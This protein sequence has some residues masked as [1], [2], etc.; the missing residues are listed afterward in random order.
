[1]LQPFISLKALISSV[2]TFMLLGSFGDAT[3]I[4]ARGQGGTRQNPI[5]V[6]IDVS[7]WPNIAE[8]NC[9]IMLCLMGRNRVFQRVQTA[10][11][12]ERAYTLSGAEWTPFQQRNL[13]KYHV[14]QINSQPGRR[15]ETSSAEEFPWRSI[16]VDPLDP[17]YVIPATLYEQSMQG[18]SLSN[19]YG[20]NR[21]DYGNFFHVTFSG[22]TGP[23]CRALHS[24]PTKPDV[25]DNHFQTILFGV[26]IML[27][28]FIYALE[29]GG[30]TRNLF[31]HM[32]GDYKG[33]V[34]PS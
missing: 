1:M 10:D 13:I 29:R 12:S 6:T 30:P 3:P 27:A 8:Q 18:N 28:N 25:C 23:Y 26:K 9:Y 22:Y 24:P 19:L 20:P 31:V 7:K 21:I 33:R 16:H 32:A 14:Q 2:F 4:N 15:T 11:E 17:R 5:P 34:W